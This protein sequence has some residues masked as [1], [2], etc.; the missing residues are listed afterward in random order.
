MPNSVRTFVLPNAVTEGGIPRLTFI[1]QPMGTHDADSWD[2]AY[3]VSFGVG[4]TATM[5]VDYT[6]YYAFDTDNLYHLVGA[7]SGTLSFPAGAGRPYRIVAIPIQ[8]NEIEADESITIRVGLPTSP[9]EPYYLWSGIDI[10]VG[11]IEDDDQD[12]TLAVAPGAVAEDGSTNLVYTFTRAG[13][14]ALSRPLVVNYTVG[15]TATLGANYSQSGAASFTTT[16]GTVVFAAGSATALVTVDPIADSAIEPDETVA[17]TLAAGTSYTIGTTA[18]V[19]G[20]ILDDDQIVSLAV[21]P[22]TSS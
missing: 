16:I 13:N 6:L 17:L 18:A 9:T 2:G 8:D 14:G 5:D 3:P 12:I 10:I 22:A 15:G 7:L 4:G 19:V 11:I 20:T 21:A 1:I